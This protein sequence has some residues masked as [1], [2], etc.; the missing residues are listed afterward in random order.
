MTLTKHDI[1]ENFNLL[2]RYSIAHFNRMCILV[3]NFKIYGQYTLTKILFPRVPKTFC[4]S[5]C[6]CV[7]SPFLFLLLLVHMA[8]KYFVGSISRITNIYELPTEL[9]SV[10]CRVILMV[11][12]QITETILLSLSLDD[13][14]R[15]SP[16]V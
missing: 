13:Y 11:D 12:L 10:I 16:L 9:L 15:P 5:E 3:M 2:Q 6:K 4:V 7:V 8:H 14:P 1:N